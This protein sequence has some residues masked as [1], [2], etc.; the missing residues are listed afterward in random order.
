MKNK[1]GVILLFVIQGLA[2]PIALFAGFIL[3]FLLVS[4]AETD[5]SQTGKTIQFVAAFLATLTGFLYIGT[6]VFSLVKTLINKKMSFISWLPTL[7]GV[8]A[9]TLLVVW[10]YV[11]QIYK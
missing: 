5:W 2:I 1:T 11:N 9:L 10:D 7:H 3:L 8:V 4:F 6:Y